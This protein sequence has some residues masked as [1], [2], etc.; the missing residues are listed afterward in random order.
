[1][2]NAQVFSNPPKYGQVVANNAVAVPVA[3][4][5]VT[6]DSIVLLCVSSAVGLNAGA[7]RV[8]SVTPGTGF[9][10]VGGAVDT[11]TYKY[12]VF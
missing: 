7:G 9:S 2:S 3:L 1:M 11:S 12:L 5:S 4:P 6:A 10:I 8:V